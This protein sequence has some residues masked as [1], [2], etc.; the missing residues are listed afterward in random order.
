MKPLFRKHCSLF[1][2]KRHKLQETEPCSPPLNWPP[3][4]QG[5][6]ENAQ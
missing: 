4:S 2:M 3:R 6:H 5:P 1:H